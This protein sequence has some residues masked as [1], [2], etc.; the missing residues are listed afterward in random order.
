M[1]PLEKVL[2]NERLLHAL[3]GMGSEEFTQ[4]LPEFEGT[5]A[6]F[7]HRIYLANPDRTRKP[8]G[9]KKGFLK[10]SADQLFFILLY[11]KCYPTY[12][13]MSF[14][15]VCD[16]SAACRR[17]Q[18]LS[19]ILERTL[20]RKLVL[21]KRQIRS[22][23]EFLKI[24]PEAREVFIDGTERPIQRPQD[25]QKQ[26]ANYSQ[27]R[28]SATPART[29]SSVP[30]RNVSDSSPRPWREKNRTLPFSEP[31]PRQDSFPLM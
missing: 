14:L 29:S 28:R 26:K 22:I 21:P 11:Y 9:G 17:Q 31:L 13:L 7:R 8:G 5:L 3:I 4:L 12:D 1:I 10:T 27:G 25:T 6:R 16:R 15:Y 23:E 19:G 2:K 24:F 18:K 30:R 20:K